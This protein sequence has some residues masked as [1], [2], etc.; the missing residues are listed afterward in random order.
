MTSLQNLTNPVSIRLIGLEPND[1]MMKIAQRKHSYLYFLTW[2]VENLFSRI[3]N[4]SLKKKKLPYL[5]YGLEPSMSGKPTCG[6][7]S[8]LK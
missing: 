6:K 5:A 8:L 1:N 3:L 7:T 2:S 4:V